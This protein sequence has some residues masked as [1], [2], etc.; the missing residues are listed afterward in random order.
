VREHA[1]TADWDACVVI[2]DERIVLGLLRGK[3]LDSDPAATAEQLMRSGP[4][5]FRPNEPAKEM[6]QHMRERGARSILVTTSDGK[7]I[8][9][10]WRE[11]A[12]RTADAVR[13]G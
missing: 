13:G 6:A 1:Q 11:D 5:T 12:E 7:L 9:L 2:N 4:T 3:E 10:L 8:G